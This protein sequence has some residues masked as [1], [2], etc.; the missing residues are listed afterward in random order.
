MKKLSPK[1]YKE[2]KSWMYRNARPIELA[3]WQ[4]YFENGSKEAVLSAL[5]FYQN[6]DGGF[7]HALEADSWNPNSS[8]YTTLKA[9]N[10]LKEIDFNDK[11]HPMMQGIFKYLESNVY[12][13]ENGWY[14]NI[15]SNDD[16][17]HAPWWTY[18]VED[19]AFEGIG[20][21]AGIISFIFLNADKNSEI[22]SKALTL[23][24]AIIGKL[25]TADKY[26]EMGIGGYCVLLDAIEQAG[27]TTYFDHKFLAEKV[28]ELVYDSIER[29]TSKWIHY[30]R[31]PS[32]YIYSPESIFYKDNEDILTK[33]LDYL[34]DTRPQNG[35]WNI[36]W[37]WFENNEK[38]AKE[39]AISEN[40]W[41][42]SVAIDKVRLLKNFNR[43]D[44]F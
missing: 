15:P 18:N 35:V 38:Y 26:G 42:A 37:S 24:D 8:P 40:W 25:N 31:R 23:S 20:V 5:S 41:K 44:R 14:F 11:Q 43:L 27:L 13:S 17:A 9:I 22:F 30:S 10:I 39:F 36:T 34:I 1:D 3:I 12:C 2:I 21:T 6:D 28:K 29:D 7:G 19:N 4:F 16:Y 33:E 32:D